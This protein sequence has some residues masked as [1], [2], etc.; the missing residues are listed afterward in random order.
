MGSTVKASGL[1]D[2][3]FPA[4]T[5]RVFDRMAAEIEW[6]DQLANQIYLV[7]MVLPVAAFYIALREQGWEKP[8]R[9]APSTMR[10]WPPDTPSAACSSSSCA[11][12]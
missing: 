7:E 2:P 3:E 6:P 1:D 12:G 9:S 5:E 4:A 10:S 8:T 11:P